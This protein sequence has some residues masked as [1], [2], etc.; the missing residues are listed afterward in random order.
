LARAKARD[1][2]TLAAVGGDS[3]FQIVAQEI[4]G[5]GAVARLALFGMGSSND[6]PRE[7]GLEAP[8]KT[9]AALE[10]GRSRRI[11]LGRVEGE[12]APS[13][14][15]IGQAS[16]GL[17][18]FVNQSAARVAARRPGLARFQTAVGVWGV[19]RA[20]RRKLVPVAL[21]IEAEGR[22]AEGRFQVANFANIRY[23]ATGRKLVPQ[24][25]P[26]DGKLDACLIREGSF[27]R[28]ARLAAAVGK[29][30]QLRAAGVE[31][32]QS[33]AFE[34]TSETPFAVQVDGEVIGGA[35]SPALF[36]SLRVRVLPGA[37]TIVA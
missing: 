16:I 4:V 14:I 20:F 12:G 7:F 5:A 15:F 28:L 27:L 31:F 13:R 33:P 25:R 22:K 3:T 36:R 11:D 21:T 9:L 37:L 34:I 17:G 26:D 32:L 2:R 19:A 18:V 35:P 6:I 30:R 24:A 29:G 23:W 8:E 1:P 10:E